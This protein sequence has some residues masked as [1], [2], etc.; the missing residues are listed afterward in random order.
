LGEVFTVFIAIL[1]G[2]GSPLLAIHLLLVNVITDAFPA[3]ALGV[4]PVNDSVMERLPV[5]KKQGVFAGGLGLIIVL[6]G[7]MV[8]ILTLIGYYL[9]S[10]VQL[11]PLFAPS[12]EVGMTMAF[13]VLALSQ[14]T[15]AINCRSRESVFKIGFFSNKAMLQAVLGS[16]AVVLC[17]C[18]IPP[19]EAIFRIVDLSMFHWLSVAGLALAPLVVVEMVKLVV[20]LRKQRG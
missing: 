14:L 7:I 2:W 15:Q 4:E 3:L 16:L 5:P 19:L 20:S 8:G 11:S 17:I 6:Q 10:F 12:H 13:L 1:F 9:G 18:L